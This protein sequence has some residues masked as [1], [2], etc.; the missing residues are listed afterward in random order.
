VSSLAQSVFRSDL[1]ARQK[2]AEAGGRLALID[3]AFKPAQPSGPGKKIFLMG[4][5]VLFLSIGLVI[6]VLLAVIDDRMYRRA[7]LDVLG[8]VV[9]G[10]IPPAPKPPKTARNRRLRAAKA[11]PPSPEKDTA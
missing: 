9:L 4:G 2:L 6:A 5:M 11:L 10:V 1:D 8:V 7:D 3:P